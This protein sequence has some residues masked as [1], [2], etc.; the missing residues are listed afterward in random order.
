MR[1]GEPFAVGDKVLVVDSKNRRYLVTL[2]EGGEFHTHAGVI[3][4]AS[5]VGQPEGTTL[6]SSSGARY[7]T[8]RPTLSDFVLSMPRGA[9]VVYPKDLG[10]LLMLADVTAGSAS[11]RRGWARGRCRWRCCRRARR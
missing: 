9:Q 3:P 6:R 7:L 1:S 5:F 2:R 11:W 4:H 8:L 10:P